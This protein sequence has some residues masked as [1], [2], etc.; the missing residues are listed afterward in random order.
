VQS[1]RAHLFANECRA[2]AGGEPEALSI[3]L[4]HPP[5]AVLAAHAVEGEEVFVDLGS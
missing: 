5:A 1:L 4:V 2:Q 3:L